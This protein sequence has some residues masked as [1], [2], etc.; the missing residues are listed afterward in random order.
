VQPRPVGAAGFS[1]GQVDRF[2]TSMSSNL[3]STRIGAGNS[4]GPSTEWSRSSSGKG[5]KKPHSKSPKKPKKPKKPQHGGGHSHN[6]G[7]GHGHH[8]RW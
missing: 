3:S 7:H 4:N 2:M 8:G 5:K 6:R 1:Q